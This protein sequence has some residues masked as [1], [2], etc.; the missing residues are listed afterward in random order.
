[1]YAYTPEVRA[2]FIL[3]INRCAVLQELLDTLFV[4]LANS[5]VELCLAWVKNVHASCMCTLVQ[6]QWNDKS[7]A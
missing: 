7:V 2:A 3:G 5:I 6:L 1:M 4:A